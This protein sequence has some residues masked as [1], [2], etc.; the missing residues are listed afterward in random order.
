MGILKISKPYISYSDNN[1]RLYSDISIDDKKIP[2]YFEVNKEW[3]EFLCYERSDAF[4]LNCLDIAMTMGI[5]IHCES[6]ISDS[7]YNNL[8]KYYIP[9]LAKEEFWSLKS[10]NIYV[11][12]ENKHNYIK[13][14]GVG[15]GFSGGVDSFYS[16]LQN[17][18][19]AA[20]RF[21]ITH[22][23]CFDFG[24]IG[25]FHRT[26]M[27]YVLNI[28]NELNIKLINICSNFSEFVQNG[29][30]RYHLLNTNFL[31]YVY[32]IQKLIHIF[33]YANG[34]QPYNEETIGRG[35]RSYR[36]AASYLSSEEVIINIEGYTAGTRL[37]KLEYI[38]ENEI[39]KKYLS[40]CNVGKYYAIGKNCSSCN[41]CIAT[42]LEAY[43]LGKLNLLSNTFDVKKFL[44]NFDE[45]FKKFTSVPYEVEKRLPQLLEKNL[46]FSDPRLSYV[47]SRFYEAEGDIE[48]AIFYAK[49]NVKFDQYQIKSWENLFML[50][51]KNKDYV[52][53]ESLALNCLKKNKHFGLMYTCLAKLYDS[54]GSIE[55]AYRN[56]IKAMNLSYNNVEVLKQHYFLL[57]KKNDH[58]SKE[59]MV[60]E[61]IKRNPSY[62]EIFEKLGYTNNK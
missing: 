6:P 9:L 61:A 55:R 62:K 24:N 41:K 7:L 17:L 8:N 51:L 32:A 54:Q 45:F 58:I 2:M 10:I 50:Y 18:N 31:A 25:S 60:Y 26:R 19:N 47:L 49:I 21:N 52:K 38:L 33:Y 22:L 12:L 53:A 28:A 43:V 59:K 3:S 14:T 30:T 37:D 35:D 56:S 34:D 36:F 48:E 15:A 57:E 4:L 39:V 29:F 46:Q 16:V 11:P 5:D 42:M 13:N 44:N 1:A 40:V 23:L 27:E 20:S